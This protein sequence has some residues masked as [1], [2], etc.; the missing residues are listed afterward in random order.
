MKI[1]KNYNQSPEGINP[2]KNKTV[3]D[4]PRDYEVKEKINC[5]LRTFEFKLSKREFF[6]YREAR[7]TILNIW[8]YKALKPSKF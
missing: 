5:K 3:N 2:F 8:Q 7:E 4:V 6:A 1:G